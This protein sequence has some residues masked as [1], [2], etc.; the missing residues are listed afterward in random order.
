MVRIREHNNT[1]HIYTNVLR[2]KM[3]NN[4]CIPHGGSKNT[5]P[6]LKIQASKH[7]PQSEKEKR[8]VQDYDDILYCREIP[9]I[10]KNTKYV[11]ITATNKQR[12]MIAIVL[13]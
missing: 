4:I 6:E 9:A 11:I 5:T 2:T 13:R 12:Y 7:K 1:V 3:C 10:R 8:R